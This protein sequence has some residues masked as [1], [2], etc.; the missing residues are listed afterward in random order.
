M[1]A[2]SVIGD[3]DCILFVARFGP[4]IEP[5]EASL[6]VFGDLRFSH[7]DELSM[8][9]EDENDSIQ[10]FC[11]PFKSSPENLRPLILAAA[12]DTTGPI[13]LANFE[14]STAYSPYDG[15]ADMFFPSNSL[16]ADSLGN[17][18]TWLSRREDGL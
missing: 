10:F 8:H 15:G 16:A 12:D 5:T 1:I 14:H 11:V 9:D 17:W 4:K 6:S 18:E 13:L 2:N 3:A 7:L